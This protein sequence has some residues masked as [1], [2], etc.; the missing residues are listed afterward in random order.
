MS[1]IPFTHKPLSS[2]SHLD[3]SVILINTESRGN[4]GSVARIMKNFSVSSLILVNP[5]ENHLDTYAMG[6]ACKA[7]DLL[8][9]AEVIRCDFSNQNSAIKKLFQR[10]DVVIGTSAK[11]ISF[12]NV[13]RIPV[14]LP[15]FDLSVLT[16]QTKVAIVFGR[17]STGLTNEQIISTDFL[18]KI[19]ANPKYPT[20][21]ISQA[22]GII[23]YDIYH[24]THVIEREQV[25]PA[26]NEQ[27]QALM[28]LFEKVVS[29]APLPDYRCERTSNAFRNIIGRAFSSQKEI[30][31]IYTFFKKLD[32]AIQTPTLFSKSTNETNKDGV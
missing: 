1:E 24:R 32:L 7:K 18:V 19:P 8:R 12:Q 10:F 9:S 5:L 3:I 28:E 23:L 25:I 15:D 20:L 30:S 29:Q 14:F 31:Y 6:F 4:I 17:E 13:K 16:N 27:K 26:S 22:V 2:F 21:N 11:G